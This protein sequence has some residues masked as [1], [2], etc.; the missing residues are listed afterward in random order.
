M[1]ALP[2]DQVSEHFAVVSLQA[3]CTHALA[4]DDV[5]FTLTSPAPMLSLLGAQHG[6]WLRITT[7]A[8]LPPAQTQSCPRVRAWCTCLA[9]HP[10]TWAASWPTSCQ[11]ETLHNSLCRLFFFF[12]QYLLTSQR[13][14]SGKLPIGATQAS[15]VSSHDCCSLPPP[16]PTIP[17]T[18]PDEAMNYRVVYHRMP[19]AHSHT[20]TVCKHGRA[21]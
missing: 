1:R 7:G 9:W 15:S 16:K 17:R 13:T 10:Q 2:K 4:G 6:L 14:Q 3:G 12:F 8:P 20:P 19:H 18:P 5:C 21:L 11:S